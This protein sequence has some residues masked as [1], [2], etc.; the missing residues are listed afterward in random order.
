LYK[1]EDGGYTWTMINDGDNIG[2]RPFYYSDLRVDPKDPNRV[3]SL[4]SLVSV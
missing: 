4:W 3:Y 1:S 2:N